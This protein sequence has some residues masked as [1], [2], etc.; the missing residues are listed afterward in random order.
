MRI[1]ILAALLA[2][3]SVDA[4]F[5][6]QATLRGKWEIEV[7]GGRVVVVNPLDGTPAG[8]AAGDEFRTVTGGL[9]LVVPTWTFGFG[10]ALWQQVQTQLQSPPDGSIASLDSVVSGSSAR[11]R[12][13]FGIGVRVSRQIASR[14]RLEGTIDLGGGHVRISE[15]ARAAIEATRA[16]YLTAWQRLFASAP[17]TFQNPSVTSE[18]TITEGSGGQLLAIGSVS[19][20]LKNIRRYV[21]YL[22]VGGGV[23]RT[24]GDPPSVSLVSRYTTRLGG[25]ALIDQTDDVRVRYELDKTL[26]VTAFGVGVRR[27]VSDRW[28]WRAEI[29]EHLSANR[30]RQILD[31][32]PSAAAGANPSA[33]PVFATNAFVGI[34]LANPSNSAARS[35]LGGPGLAGVQSFTGTGME[36][37]F[38]A[39]IGVF[40]RF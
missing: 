25:A 5:A 24:L 10:N 22:M 19:V 36:S 8:E 38:A 21:P 3:S 33:E 9:S 30:M 13:G 15:E 1:R 11:P 32:T 26:V 20:D 29:R 7:H 40:L 16:S 18:A 17:S 27:M 39:T 4:A 2:V 31:A 28:G 12:S 35:S 14:V 34:Q 23:L 6:Q 37:R